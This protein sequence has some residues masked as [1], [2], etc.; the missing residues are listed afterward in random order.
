MYGSVFSSDPVKPGLNKTLPCRI[1]SERW[2]SSERRRR[3][4]LSPPQAA[5]S[6]RSLSFSLS[7]QSSATSRRRQSV[8]ISTLLAIARTSRR[9]N[10]IACLFSWLGFSEEKRN[11]KKQS[12]S[13]LRT[14]HIWLLLCQISVRK[15][16]GSSESSRLYIR[17]GLIHCSSSAARSIGA[18]LRLPPSPSEFYTARANFY[19]PLLFPSVSL[20]CR[21]TLFALISEVVVV[22]ELQ[23]RLIFQFL[24]SLRGREILVSIRSIRRTKQRFIIKISYMLAQVFDI[25]T[26]VVIRFDS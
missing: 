12:R 14:F 1:S 17:V 2:D 5:A 15:R 11:L 4:S 23:V 10:S 16:T 8:G 19:F 24:C 25:S 13:N 7:R 9:L 26:E 3:V 21:L 22:A 18:L 20:L 6:R